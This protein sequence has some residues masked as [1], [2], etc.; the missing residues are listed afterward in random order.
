MSARRS[1]WKRAAGRGHVGDHVTAAL[2]VPVNR[3]S[4]N[5]LGA[6]GSMSYA[7]GA[8]P[9][10]L[11]AS[12]CSAE[13]APELACSCLAGCFDELADDRVDDE[14]SDGAGNGR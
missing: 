3:A 1:S 6:S 4:P 8:N 12:G 13:A 14:T 9:C 5:A 2:S 11:S 10:D 7:A